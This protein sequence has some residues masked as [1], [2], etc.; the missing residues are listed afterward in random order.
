M[1]KLF[2]VTLNQHDSYGTSNGTSYSMSYGTRKK[3]Q[4]RLIYTNITLFY[5]SPKDKLYSHCKG[6]TTI[7][8]IFV[9]SVKLH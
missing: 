6:Y 5:T 1:T 7:L 9:L 8:K 4:R 2:V 3:N